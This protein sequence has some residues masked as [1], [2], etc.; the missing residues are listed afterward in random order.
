VSDKSIVLH[1]ALEDAVKFLTQDHSSVESWLYRGDFSKTIAA[2]LTDGIAGL[3]ADNARLRE[4]V[5]R[6]KDIIRT[7]RE[8]QIV[9]NDKVSEIHALVTEIYS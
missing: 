8:A 3:E 2:T 9:M 5:I 1:R 6:L 4:D 7:E